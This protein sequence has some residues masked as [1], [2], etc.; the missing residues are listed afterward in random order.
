MGSLALGIRSEMA[1]TNQTVLARSLSNLKQF[2]PKIQKILTRPTE[3]YAQKHKP[4]RLLGK[5]RWLRD[6]YEDLSRLRA[7][8]Q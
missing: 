6:F 8:R 7:R 4:N 1:T 5:T 2:R 3:F